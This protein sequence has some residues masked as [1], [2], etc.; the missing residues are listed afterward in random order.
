MQTLLHQNRFFE[1]FGELVRSARVPGVEIRPQIFRTLFH[2]VRQHVFFGAV[3][4]FAGLIERRQVDLVGVN[5]STRTNLV[6]QAKLES[7][8]FFKSMNL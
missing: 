5:V 7:Y 4:Q 1:Q 6:L 8:F 3:A 2:Q